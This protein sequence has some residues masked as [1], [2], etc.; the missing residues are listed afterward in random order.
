VAGPA[1]GEAPPEPSTRARDHPYPAAVDLA[2]PGCR[3]EPTV[4]MSRNVASTAATTWG[5]C[6]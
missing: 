1:P 6:G 5:S 3:V 2:E 4:Y